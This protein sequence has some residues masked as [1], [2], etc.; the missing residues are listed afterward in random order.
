MK[1]KLIIVENDDVWKFLFQELLQKIPDV[2]VVGEFERAEAA[3]EQIPQL[4]PDL[5]I[6]DIS[7]PGMSG[8]AFAE[9]M[10]KYPAT[11][12]IFVTSHQQEYRSQLHSKEFQVVDK[13]ETGLIRDAIERAMAK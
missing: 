11:R 10:R 9:E 8:L 1:T 4:L 13:G 2:V 5:A 3:L 7:L 6:V 12:I